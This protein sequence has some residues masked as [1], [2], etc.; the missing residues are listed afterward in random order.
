MKVKKSD[1]ISFV[2][3]FGEVYPNIKDKSLKLALHNIYEQLDRFI[4][5]DKPRLYELQDW[6]YNEIFSKKGSYANEIGKI[7]SI[8]SLF[9]SWI[10][11]NKINKII[12]VD[13][14]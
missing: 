12:D 3:S 10:R 11:D 4:L 5:F 13:Q 9:L 8:E 6:E 1:I 7:E 14:N 2:E